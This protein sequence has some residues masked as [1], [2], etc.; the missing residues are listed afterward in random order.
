[1]PTG[2]THAHWTAP[3]NGFDRR[4]VVIVPGRRCPD[5]SS[6]AA[7]VE[8]VGVEGGEE[9]EDDGGDEGEDDG[10]ADVAAELAVGVADLVPPGV[11]VALDPDPSHAAPRAG[12]RSHHRRVE[13]PAGFR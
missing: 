2:N 6:A 13:L 3:W 5:G 7:A 11:R 8:G 10:A 4:A 9:D 1:M 12:R